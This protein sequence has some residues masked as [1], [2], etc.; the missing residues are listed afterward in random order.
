[1][2]FVKVQY[3]TYNQQFTAMD[4]ELATHLDDGS[5]YLVA[6]FSTEDFLPPSAE[7]DAPGASHTAA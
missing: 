2:R 5:L 3:D 6:D 4:R 1:M 7:A